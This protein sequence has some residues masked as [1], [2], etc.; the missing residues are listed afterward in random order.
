MYQKKK[1]KFTNPNTYIQDIK[2]HEKH[3]KYLTFK[4]QIAVKPKNSTRK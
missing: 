2:I 4:T 1:R 3:I